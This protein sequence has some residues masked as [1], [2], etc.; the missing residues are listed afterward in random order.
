MLKCIKQHERLSNSSNVMP[1]DE[2][3]I[4]DV[5]INPLITYCFSGNKLI[6]DLVN[7]HIA[8]GQIK[9]FRDKKPVIYFFIM[10]FFNFS[11][12]VLRSSF[13]VFLLF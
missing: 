6:I 8:T 11:S 9:T 10:N 2:Q 4:L 7:D 13:L 1:G 5:D 12:F 3:E